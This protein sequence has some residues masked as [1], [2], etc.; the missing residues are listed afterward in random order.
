MIYEMFHVLNCGIKIIASLI[1][2]ISSHFIF[3]CLSCNPCMLINITSLQTIRPNTFFSVNGPNYFQKTKK[4]ESRKGA[5]NNKMLPSKNREQCNICLIV[6][7]ATFAVLAFCFITSWFVSLL[8]LLLL[9]YLVFLLMRT[10]ACQRISFQ[11]L[12]YLRLI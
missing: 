8:N 3:F 12:L 11:I 9:G 7:F 5:L 1:K 6:T 10:L 2:K 4:W